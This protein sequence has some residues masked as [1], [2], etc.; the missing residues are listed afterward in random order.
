MSTTIIGEYK[1]VTITN[2]QP[3]TGPIDLLGNRLMGIIW[4]AVMTNSAFKVQVSG[5]GID[6]VDLK[7][8]EAASA[9]LSVTVSVGEAIPITNAAVL[10]GW[11][12]IQ[13]VG[14]SNELG[15]R[16]LILAVRPV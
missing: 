5:N 16:S 1:T 7:T 6:F 13:L 2:G 9:D 12:W 10:A 11:R 15:D 14:S 4:P 8:T 3:S